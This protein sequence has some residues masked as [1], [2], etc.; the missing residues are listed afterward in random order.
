MRP[1]PGL[2]VSPAL[3]GLIIGH[4]VARALDVRFLFT[5]RSEGE[6]C[7]RRGFAV[8]PGER[9]AVVED[10][11]TT[12]RSTREVIALLAAADAEVIA[13]G[14][15]VDRTGRTGVFAP[16]AFEALL[17]VK[18]PTWDPADCPLCRAGEPLVKPGSRP[19]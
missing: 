9:I 18:F 15:V 1:A 6:M 8:A 19:I 16:A 17:E 3:G 13:V 10:V 7:L 14:A 12:G 4:E 2:V 5:E 11:V